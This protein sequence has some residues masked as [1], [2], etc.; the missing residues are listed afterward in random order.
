MAPQAQPAPTSWV[1]M[2]LGKHLTQ[3]GRR[4][5]T[6]LNDLWRSGKDE[7]WARQLRNNHALWLRRQTTDTLVMHITNVAYIEAAN[8]L[9][10]VDGEL[11]IEDAG[12]VSESGQ[13]PGGEEGAYVQAWVWVPKEAMHRVM[14]DAHQID[15]EKLQ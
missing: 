12:R 14:H 13:N 8:G 2:Q 5:R 10:A 1:L 15:L 4:W 11:E 9:H 3:H 7:P 6:K